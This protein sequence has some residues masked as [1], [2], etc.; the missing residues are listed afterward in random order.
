MES[1]SEKTPKKVLTKASTINWFHK[2]FMRQVSQSNGDLNRQLTVALQNQ[3][4]IQEDD[5]LI[6]S[7][8]SVS[9]SK[10][11]EIQPK[12]KPTLTRIRMTR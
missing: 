6:T 10:V 9:S 2:T 8:F 1:E 7:S 4:P 5:S 12:P 11:S 3:E